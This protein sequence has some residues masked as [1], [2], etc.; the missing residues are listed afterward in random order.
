LNAPKQAL[1]DE[2]AESVVHRLERDR[3]DLGP[4]GFGHT[5]GRDVGLPRNRPQHG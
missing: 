2:E 3:T 5:V 4:D 1:S